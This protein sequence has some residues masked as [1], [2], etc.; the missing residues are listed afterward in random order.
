MPVLEDCFVTA[1]NSLKAATNFTKVGV[2]FCDGII[3]PR[4]KSL[5]SKLKFIKIY[6]RSKKMHA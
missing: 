4:L 2:M 5:F 3:I 6:L 1:F